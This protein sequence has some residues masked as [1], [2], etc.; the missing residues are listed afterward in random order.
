MRERGHIRTALLFKFILQL[1]VK[2]ITISLIDHFIIYC[3][4][5]NM[6]KYSTALT[7]LSSSIYSYV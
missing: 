5:Y 6:S 4:A 7:A 1:T 2:Q 3:S